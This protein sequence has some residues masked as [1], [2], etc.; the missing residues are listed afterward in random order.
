ML[1]NQ[2]VHTIIYLSLKANDNGTKKCKMLYDIPR[3]I[4]AI[5]EKMVKPVQDYARHFRVKMERRRS[6]GAA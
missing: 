4:N 5:T 3:N 6:R 2:L 1:S